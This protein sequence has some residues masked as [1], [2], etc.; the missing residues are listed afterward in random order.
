M[1]DHW[2]NPRHHRWTGSVAVVLV[3]PGGD[4]A[5]VTV[6]ATATMEVTK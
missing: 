2:T 1:S 5:S 4:V 6:T 3:W